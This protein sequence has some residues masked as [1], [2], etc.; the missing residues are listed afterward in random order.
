MINNDKVLKEYM[1]KGEKLVIFKKPTTLS[2]ISGLIDSV[3]L[4]LIDYVDIGCVNECLDEILDNKQ[5][6]EFT[7]IPNHMCNLNIQKMWGMV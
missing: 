5:I 4:K 1:N 6:Q 3:S 7:T 2:N